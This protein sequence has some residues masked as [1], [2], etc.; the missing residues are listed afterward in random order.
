MIRKVWRAAGDTGRLTGGGDGSWKGLATGY[1]AM[2]GRVVDKFEQ[3]VAAAL[4]RRDGLAMASRAAKQELTR[5]KLDLVGLRDYQVDIHTWMAPSSGTGGCARRFLLSLAR[6]TTERRST[7]PHE[8]LRRRASSVMPLLA[9]LHHTLSSRAGMRLPA[10]SQ[11]SGAHQLEM[12][13]LIVAWSSPSSPHP[14]EAYAQA[15][16]GLN[17]PHLLFIQTT[18][19]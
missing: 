1:R 4:W 11:A 14:Q 18:S 19:N 5:R 2:L 6:G 16:L 3:A 7:T 8:V 15:P 9:L 12:S 10:S 13:S 17:P